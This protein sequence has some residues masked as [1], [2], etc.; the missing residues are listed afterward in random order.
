MSLLAGGLSSSSAPCCWVRQKVRQVTV[1]LLCVN[2]GLNESLLVI[3]YFF[4]FIHLVL[5]PKVRFE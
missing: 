5:T 1:I 4:I 2:K 3:F